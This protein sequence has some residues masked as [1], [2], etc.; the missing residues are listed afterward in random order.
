MKKGLTF[1]VL[2][3]SLFSHFV[4][5]VS[6]HDL[7]VNK[8]V[9]FFKKTENSTERK[10]ILDRYKKITDQE[11]LN[12]KK[13]KPTRE[14]LDKLDDVAKKAQQAQDEL[15]HDVLVKSYKDGEKGT[16]RNKHGSFLGHALFGEG[17]FGDRW[18]EYR[19][20]SK[21]QDEIKQ[22]QEEIKK[23]DPHLMGENFIQ[24]LKSYEIE[25][26]QP[27]QIEELC[28]AYF[29]R[30][31]VT[32]YGGII[33]SSAGLRITAFTPDQIKSFDT[34][35]VQALKLNVLTEGQIKAFTKEQVRSLTADQIEGT[36]EYNEKIRRRQLKT[37]GLKSLKSF[38]SEQLLWFTPKQVGLFT[39][40]QIESLIKADRIKD[41]SPEQRQELRRTLS[42]EIN[43][44]KLN[45]KPN[46]T[47]INRI[48]ADMKKINF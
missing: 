38:T 11:R 45:E 25:A 7:Y 30:R 35:Q 15:D 21:A 42:T 28:R 16:E 13:N 39:L 40:E 41:L 2:A 10:D 37:L 27:K 47:L 9:N 34:K 33:T 43:Q 24:D 5:I 19:A 36:Y 46:E 20:A 6:M 22:R 31:V 1:L 3:C 14:Y 29:N 32:S 8:D 12:F 18:R 17:N 44:I 23:I 4:K 48:Q 26:L